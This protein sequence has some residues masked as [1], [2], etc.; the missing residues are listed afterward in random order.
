MDGWKPKFDDSGNVGNEG[1]LSADERREG[2]RHITV[3]RVAKVVRDSGDEL[4]VI[5]NIS[6]GGVMAH[7][8]APARIGERVSIEFKS[9]R[10]L[11]GEVRWVR[12]SNAGIEFVEKIDIMRF[13]AGEDDVSEGLLPR[14]PRLGLGMPATVR[15]GIRMHAVT[16]HDIS[17]GGLK[18]G[19]LPATA[20]G[21]TLVFRIAGLP[22][23]TGTVR[24]CDEE[25][26]GV[27]FDTPLK[28]EQLARWVAEIDRVQ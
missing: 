15:A 6:D 21:D 23:L 10:A 20:V 22:P 28:L 24:W 25:H 12:D 7:L 5:R 13:L 2:R 11:E 1:G 18:F 3:L 16:I 8:Y 27:A 4:C 17:Q 19:R 9:G 26:A 14:A